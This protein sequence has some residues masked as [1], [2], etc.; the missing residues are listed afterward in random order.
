MTATHYALKPI[1][2]V[3]DVKKPNK[4]IFIAQIEVN[5]EHEL[6]LMHPT[7]AH[8]TKTGVHSDPAAYRAC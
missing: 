5:D 4:P 3:S 8:N 2:C 7:K 6:F 1:W